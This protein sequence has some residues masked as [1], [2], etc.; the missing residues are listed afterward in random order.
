MPLVLDPSEWAVKWAENEI[1]EDV[2]G[3]HVL[4][5][6]A[7]VVNL[8]YSELGQSAASK[9][10][11]EAFLHELEVWRAGLSETFVGIP[12]GGIDEDGFRKVYFPVA[13]AAAA[14]FWYHII[15]ILLY[16][17]PTL[18]DELFAFNSR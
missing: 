4:W 1:R 14:T 3:N 10:R 15:H 17:E 5:I 18:Q 8:A 16:A 12:Y 13:A 11:R 9:D 2:L 6:L 7:K